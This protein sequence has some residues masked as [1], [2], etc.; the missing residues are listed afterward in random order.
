MNDIIISATSSFFSALNLCMIGVME[1]GTQRE[2]GATN[3]T[4]TAFFLEGGVTKSSS[5]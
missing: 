1:D 4:R 5:S 2:T 3:L